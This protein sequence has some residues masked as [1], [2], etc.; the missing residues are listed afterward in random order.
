MSHKNSVC[1]SVVM[2]LLQ[3]LKGIA[4]KW[5]FVNFVTMVLYSIA[6]ISICLRNGCKLHVMDMI[7]IKGNKLYDSDSS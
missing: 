2:K 5:K 1:C 4:Y 7:M 6:V 3:L